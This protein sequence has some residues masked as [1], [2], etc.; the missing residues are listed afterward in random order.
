MGR[1]NPLA[2]KHTYRLSLVDNETHEPIRSIRFGKAQGIYWII[3]AVLALLLFFYLIFAFTPLRTIIPGYPNAH[4]KKEAVANAIKIDS[5]E[6]AVIRWNVYAEHLSRVL[7][8]ESSVD[9]DS[10]VRAGSARYLSDKDADEL[11]R[12][13]SVLR[14]TVL[15]EEQFGVSALGERDLP[16]EGVHFFT[17]I[18]GV[19]SAGFE[20]AVHPYIEIAAPTGTVVSAVLDGTVVFTAWDAEQGYIVILQHRGD[21][22]SV[23]TNNQKLLRSAGDVVKAGTPIALVGGTSR[24]EGAEHLHFELWQN[25]ESLDPTRFISF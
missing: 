24:S 25:G 20:R 19:V 4:S 10:L 9:F 12:Q 11:V 22:L 1:Q 5:L 8:G 14:E 3:T 18:K 7:T 2:G 6:N 16:I 23:Y 13:D 17:P 21:L 15:K